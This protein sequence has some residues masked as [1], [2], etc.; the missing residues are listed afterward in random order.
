M[1]SEQLITFADGQMVLDAF[2]T[3]YG[4][5]Q[6]LYSKRPELTISCEG[7]EQMLERIRQAKNAITSREP[8]LS[9]EVFTRIRSHPLSISFTEGELNAI[10]QVLQA[11]VDEARPNPPHI[12][13]L[14]GRIENICS[15]IDKLHQIM[16]RG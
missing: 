1:N 14:V 10:V 13:A 7:Q 2:R 16:Y 15:L 6:L 9:P 4:S 11:V 5:M 3:I 12:A 8:R